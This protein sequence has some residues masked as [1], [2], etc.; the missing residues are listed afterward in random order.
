M[1]GLRSSIGQLLCELCGECGHPEAPAPQLVAASPPFLF[2]LSVV[3][4][5]VPR[6]S[7]DAGA[8]AARS[9][10]SAPGSPPDGGASRSTSSLSRYGM[11]RGMSHPLPRDPLSPRTRGGAGSRWTYLLH[12]MAASFSLLLAQTPSARRTPGLHR[13]LKAGAGP[14]ALARPRRIR[15]ACGSCARKRGPPPGARR[16]SSSIDRAYGS[17]CLHHVDLPSLSGSRRIALPNDRT[18]RHRCRWTARM[19]GSSH[20]RRA[21]RARPA[22]IATVPAPTRRSR[23]ADRPRTPHAT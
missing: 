23:G 7:S 4:A 16:P 10:T 11:C 17:R 5:E 12:T 3:A 6:A 8:P 9:F 14:L 15:G 20:C 13:R 1:P 22:S 18:H 2:S 19:P 21:D